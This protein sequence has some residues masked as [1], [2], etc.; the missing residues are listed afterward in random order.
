MAKEKSIE[1]GAH[2]QRIAPPLATRVPICRASS[3]YKILSYFTLRPVR[4]WYA[5]ANSV[6]AQFV[7][8]IGVEEFLAL[9]WDNPN[10]APQMELIEEC[11]HAA[12]INDKINITAQV[13]P[14]QVRIK[15]RIIHKVL[16]LPLGMATSLFT[17]TSR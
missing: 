15:A 14:K 11:V 2:H 12:V 4:E 5:A 7:K 1:Q 13:Q 9:D 10:W 3:M 8:D 6:E 17:T 16:K